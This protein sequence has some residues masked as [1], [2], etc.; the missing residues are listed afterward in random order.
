VLQDLRP[1]GIRFEGFRVRFEGFRVV[2][3]VINCKVDI[4]AVVR[5][6]QAASSRKKLSS[7]DTFGKI[8][9]E[10]GPF[11]KLRVILVGN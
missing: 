7:S 2:D 10:Q 1:R 11:S 9:W 6:L 5:V 8:V 3:R 4:H